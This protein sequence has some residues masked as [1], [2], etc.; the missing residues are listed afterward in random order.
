MPQHPYAT[1]EK[2]AM[3]GQWAV[4]TRDSFD[5]NMAWTAIKGSDALCLDVANA[6]EKHG[7]TVFYNPTRAALEA[8]RNACR[9]QERAALAR[10]F[11]Q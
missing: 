10:K 9:Q 3:T 4:L 2:D 5:S 7:Y 8:W 1:V 6:L 11:G